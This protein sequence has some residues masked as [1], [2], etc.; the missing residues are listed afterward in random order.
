VQDAEHERHVGGVVDGTPSPGFSVGGEPLAQD[1]RYHQQDDEIGCDGAEP[2]VEGPVRREKGDDRIDDV[3]PLRQDL[4]HDVDDQEGQRAEGEGPVHGL[5]HHPVPGRHHDPVGGDQ[6]EQHGTGEADERQHPGVVEHEM[7][8]RRVDVPAD[9]GQGQY[10]HDDDGGG[11]QRCRDLPRV[12][13]SR[14]LCPRM[15]TLTTA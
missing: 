10:G 8:R 4:G 9:L 12:V 11:D 14:S 3:R 7:L 1:A 5:G 2:D 15:H 6:A 13:S